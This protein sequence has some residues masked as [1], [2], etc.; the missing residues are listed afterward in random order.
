M[1][2]Y[3]EKTR[4]RIKNALEALVEEG[5]GRKPTVS[6][7]LSRSGVAR[8][9]FYVYYGNFQDLLEELASDYAAEIIRLI[10]AN[11]GRGVGPDS[12]REAYGIFIRFIADH[13][14]AYAMLLRNARIERVFLEGIQEYLYDQYL[15]DFPDKDPKLLRYSACACTSYVYSILRQWVKDGFRESPEELAKLLPDSIQIA[16]DLYGP[17]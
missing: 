6:E 11:R 9:T 8:S 10:R 5:A 15:A 13:K 16:T 12:Y 17:K 3:G 1:S 7:V 14:K 2:D 4:A